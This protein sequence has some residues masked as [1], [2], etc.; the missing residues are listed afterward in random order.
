[1]TKRY[2]TA[3]LSAIAH[4]QWLASV[5]ADKAKAGA[6]RV[7]A[8]KVRKPVDT[9]NPYG[10]PASEV[11]V[12]IA[13]KRTKTDPSRKEA[14]IEYDKE[15]PAAVNTAA[16]TGAGAPVKANEAPIVVPPGAIHVKA[17]SFVKSFAE[18]TYPNDPSAHVHVFDC[19]TGGKQIYF[20]RSMKSIWAE[21]SLDIP[22]AGTYKMEIMVATANRDQVLDVSS[23]D[24]KLG[25]IKIAGTIGLWKKMDPMDIPL[26]KGAQTLRISG[27]FQ[28]GVAIRWFQLTPK[29]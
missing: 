12:V 21:Y 7:L 19:Y 3:E 2:R 27:P 4:I 11:D 17:E 1:M 28:R 8:L 9:S 24:A 15:G 22:E 23:G 5:Q 25:T 10:V 20:P 29:K 13:G 26:K 16:R 14:A 18:P 6:L